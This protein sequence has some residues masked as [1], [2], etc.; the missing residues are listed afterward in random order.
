MCVI[1]ILEIKI[2]SALL[3]I[4]IKSYIRELL[5]KEERFHGLI[6]CKGVIA[7]AKATANAKPDYL[8]LPL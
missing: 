4:L 3:I 5:L 1:L 7:N 6:Q 2:S 8:Q